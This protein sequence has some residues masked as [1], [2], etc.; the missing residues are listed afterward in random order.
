MWTKLMTTATA[1]TLVAAPALTQEVV[2]ENQGADEL[3]GDWI[4][5]ATV[6]SVEGERIGPIDDVILDAEEGNV[7]A[8]VISVG[9]FLGFGAKSIAVEWSE[10]EIDWDGSDITL[11]LTREQAEEAPEYAFRDR[12]LE[13]P[14]A[15]EEGTGTGTTGTGATGTTGTGALD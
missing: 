10:L 4:V 12:E 13:P 7:T 1:L 8:A 3:R 9:G 14:P 15:P 2:V 11:D 5:G 6:T